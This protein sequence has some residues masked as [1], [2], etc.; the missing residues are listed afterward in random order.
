MNY[1]YFYSLFGKYVRKKLGYSLDNFANMSGYS[2]SYLS[3]TEN[4]NR[5]YSEDRFLNIIK[6]MKID[7]SQNKQFQELHQNN[8]YN[9]ISYFINLSPALFQNDKLQYEYHERDELNYGCFYYLLLC[10]FYLVYFNLPS[11]ETERY[12]FAALKIGVVCL[13]PD[14]RAFFHDLYALR[15]ID[16]KKYS[17]AIDELQ[18]AEYFADG[19][20]I[21][22]IFGIIHY[23]KLQALSFLNRYMDTFILSSQVIKE[24]YDLGNPALASYAQN[25]KGISL[26][27]LGYYERAEKVFE[28]IRNYSKQFKNET[29]ERIVYQNSLVNLFAWGKYEEVLLYY[30][31]W[32]SKFI[33]DLYHLIAFSYYKLGK[34]KDCKS[35]IQNLSS[36]KMKSINVQFVKALKYRLSGKEEKFEKQILYL[37]HYYKRNNDVILLKTTLEWLIDFYHDIGNLQKIAVIQS[38]YITLLKT[39]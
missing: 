35:F 5:F 15:L 26:E 2:K 6:S 34:I 14:L 39:I 22:Q 27:Y 8:L 23:H 33:Y 20:Y 12:L 7:F 1:Q 24:F 21:S 3:E 25:L 10:Y 18:K 37:I 19:K 9:E 17:L 29:L 31:L 38:E 13:E 11:S 4:L 32:S 36:D 16:R 28:Q 30:N